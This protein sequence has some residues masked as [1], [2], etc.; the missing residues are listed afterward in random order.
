MKKP[1]L[2]PLLIVLAFVVLMTNLGFW[3]LNRAEEKEGLLLLLAD[4][5]VTLVDNAN[6][7]KTLPQYAN[8][9][10]TGRFLDAPQLLLDNQI[11]NQKVGYHVFT[12]FIIDEM[13]L[14]LMINRG[15]IPKEGYD[16]NSLA[17][18]TEALTLQGKL[19]HSPQV[20]M[21]LGEIELDPNKKQ[22]IMTYFDRPI[23][24]RFLHENLCKDLNCIVSNRVMLLEKNQPQGFKREWN[25]IIMPPAKHTGYAVQWFSM[26]IVLILLF[27]YWVSKLKD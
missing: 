27:V 1:P 7:I 5:K 19:N 25:P 2:I 21:Q 6:Q 26:T 20:G 3:Q 9:K 11:N 12:P 23:V 13:N 15:W 14:Y 18:S 10:I 17:I 22:Q 24:S 16:Q 4:D 8:I